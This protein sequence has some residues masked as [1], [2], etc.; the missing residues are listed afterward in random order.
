MYENWIQASFPTEI[1]LMII[2]LLPT[3]DVV[4]LGHTCKRLH[5]IAEQ[6]RAKRQDIDRLLKRYVDDTHSFR[7]LMRDTGGIIVGDF[8]RA[9][10]TGEDPPKKLELL[11]NGNYDED[12]QEGIKLWTAF[13]GNVV[14]PQVA[15]LRMQVVLDGT[16]EVSCSSDIWN[17]NIVT[18]KMDRN[19]SC[20]GRK[21]TQLFQCD[22]DMCHLWYMTVFSHN[23]FSQ[24]LMLPCLGIATS[25]PGTPPSA[26]IL[27]WYRETLRRVC[28]QSWR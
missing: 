25:F 16:H 11:F 28:I 14:K 8:A 1:L 19:I 23:T 15:G 13:F 5:G 9:F 2:T 6:E 12:L 24:L 3:K 7:R 4:L 27:V 18:L 26:L 22:F 17:A 10:F 21:T 20:F